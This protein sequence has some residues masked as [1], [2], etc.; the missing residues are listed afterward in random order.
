MINILSVEINDMFVRAQIGVPSKERVYHQ[1]L[2]VDVKCIIKNITTNDKDLSSTY[3]Y[4]SLRK[5][6]MHLAEVSRF[7]L[8]ESL[9][10][11][12]AEFVFTDLRIIEVIIE[13]KKPNRFTDT[14]AV[15]IKA[16]FKRSKDEI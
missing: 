8:L 11:S 1:P 15:G 16:T 13:I 2:V 6:I 14:K 5:E 7:H 3:D 12:I 9:A 4:S 10:S